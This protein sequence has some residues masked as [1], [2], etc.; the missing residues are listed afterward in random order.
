MTHKCFECGSDASE[1]HHVVPRSLGGT[2]TV[3]LCP[4]C[5]GKVHGV[6]RLHVSSLTK[7]AL[8]VKKSQGVRLGRPVLQAA[9]TEVKVLQLRDQ[10]LS[11]RT[12]AE[13]LNTE[14]VPTASG[15]AKWHAS[16]VRVILERDA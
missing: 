6:Q 1:Q 8:A 7:E 11:M 16:T 2:K 15:G 3:W 10:G 12:I 5:H 9:E 4:A 13:I 14:G